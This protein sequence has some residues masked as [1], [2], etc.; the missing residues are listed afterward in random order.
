MRRFMDED[1]NEIDPEAWGIYEDE[2][3]TPAEP[4]NA[5]DVVVVLVLPWV[6]FVN[7]L[8]ASVNYLHSALAGTS[9]RIDA[10]RRFAREAG[11]SIES[12]TGGD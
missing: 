10:R 11:L 7:G 2:T 5:A 12:M 9:A 4:M 1:G 6:G 3:E 8:A